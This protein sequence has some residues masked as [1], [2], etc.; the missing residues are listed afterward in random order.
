MRVMRQTGTALRHSPA[1]S[2]LMRFH[3]GIRCVTPVIP[4]RFCRLLGR[5]RAN[6]VSIGST[7]A[8]SRAR[9]CRQQ[10][11]LSLNASFLARCQCLIMSIVCIKGLSGGG[12][13][14][15]REAFMMRTEQLCT[16]SAHDRPRAHGT[17]SA[18]CS[19]AGFVVSR[20]KVS[21]SDGWAGGC[22]VASIGGSLCY[23]RSLWGRLSVCWFDGGWSC[24][25]A[26][27]RARRA[28]CRSSLSTRSSLRR[29]RESSVGLQSFA[30]QVRCVPPF[31]I[32]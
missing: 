12:G 11:A 13:N 7:G 29:H 8:T 24:R 22:V 4:S 25:R 17:V 19:L 2:P 23:I 30:K 28:T 9:F 18:R 10:A 21:A 26:G 1:F 27:L 20:S 14:L 6:K 3:G 15:Y 31:T 16:R 32:E 5:S